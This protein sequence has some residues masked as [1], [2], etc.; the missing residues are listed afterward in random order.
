MANVQKPFREET[1]INEDS[2][3]NLRRCDTGK[4]YDVKSTIN[5][6]FLIHAIYYA[7]PGSGEHF[8]LCTHL[9]AVKGATSFEDLHRV[10]GG[11][12][13]PTFHQAC[14]AHG[15]LEG[16]NEWRQCFLE[17]AHMASGHQLR[18]LFVTILHD[19]SPSDLLVLWLEFRFVMTFDMISIPKILFMTLL[20]NK[21]LT[22][23][24]TLL[25]ESFM[26]ATS[27]SRIGKPCH[28][29]RMTL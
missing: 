13:L 5:G 6:L 26:V 27:L 12:P 15:L 1:S 28:F 20:K 8:Y 14:L 19:C 22:M 24:F 18:N 21:C 29:L 11:D 4:T 7:H 9:A 10:D 16:D 25:M 3:A 23:A 17:A 2:Y